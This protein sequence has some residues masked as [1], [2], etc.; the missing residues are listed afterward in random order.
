M[1]D[2]E[3]RINPPPESD[4]IAEERYTQHRKALGDAIVRKC[5]DL[6]QH[7][8]LIASDDNDPDQDMTESYARGQLRCIVQ[9]TTELEILLLNFVRPNEERE[10]WDNKL[11]E[12]K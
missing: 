9:A 7:T 3:P 6:I 4:G 12:P 10:Y 11:R 1:I 2:H 8:A 5:Q